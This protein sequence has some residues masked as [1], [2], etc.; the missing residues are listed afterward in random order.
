VDH[1]KDEFFRKW[2]LW[3]AEPQLINNFRASLQ[4]A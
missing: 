1:T 4:E 3:S 2:W